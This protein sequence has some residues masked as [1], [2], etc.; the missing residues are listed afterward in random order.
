MCLWLLDLTN[1]NTDGSVKSEF[2]YTTSK[3]V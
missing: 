1:K 2:R 3:L